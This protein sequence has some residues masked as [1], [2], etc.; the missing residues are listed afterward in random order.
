MFNEAYHQN[1]AIVTN[2]Y[3]SLDIREALIL[4]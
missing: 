1:A 3:H 2:Y 4:C